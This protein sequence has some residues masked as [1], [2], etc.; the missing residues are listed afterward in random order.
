LTFNNRLGKPTPNPTMKWIF[1]CFEGI[2][3]LYQTDCKPV[4]TNLEEEHELILNLFGSN[5]WRF[6]T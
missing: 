3:V 5:Y 2:H 6:Y 1:E 4:V